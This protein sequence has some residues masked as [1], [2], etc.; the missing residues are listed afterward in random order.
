MADEEEQSTIFPSKKSLGIGR[1]KRSG[2]EI[3]RD[4]ILIARNPVGYS[5]AWRLSNQEYPRWLGFLNQLLELGLLEKV[6]LEDGKKNG[7]HATV[8]GME[9]V[10]ALNK[11]LGYLE[12]PEKQIQ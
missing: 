1:T 3:M 9:F 6:E 12:Y 7:L 10:E 4:I 8:R 5:T 2:F 11:A